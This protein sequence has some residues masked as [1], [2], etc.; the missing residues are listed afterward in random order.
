MVPAAPFFIVFSLLLIAIDKKKSYLNK[1]ATF[2]ISLVIYF[3][4][5]AIASSESQD[6][7]HR[8]MQAGQEQQY[9]R[10]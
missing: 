6:N 3:G 10:K 9:E 7:V 4:I 5:L 8:M 2:I 1:L